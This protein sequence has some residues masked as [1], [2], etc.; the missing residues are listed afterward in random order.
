MERD[1]TEIRAGHRLI[2]KNHLAHTIS[3]YLAKNPLSIL[4]QAAPRAYS[5]NLSFPDELDELLLDDLY[6]L[7]HAFEEDA[8]KE[9]RDQRWWILKAALADRG[10]GIRLFSNREMLE[11]IFEEF[12]V[13]S[14][15]EE[16]EDDSE[17]ETEKGPSHG[18]GKE[19]AVNASQMREWTIQ[20]RR[21]L[22]YIYIYFLSLD[23]CWFIADILLQEYISK[24]LL[25]DPVLGST[26]GRK[27]HLR[28]ESRYSKSAVP[29]LT[30]IESNVH[31]VYVVAVSALSVYVHH[32]YLALFAPTPYDFPPTRGDDGTVDLSSHLTNTCIQ[33]VDDEQPPALV[34]STW[35]SLAEHVILGEGA[36]AGEKLG[37]ERI[38]K[39]ENDVGE[40]VSETFRAGISSGSG[41]Q[42]GSCHCL[43]CYKVDANQRPQPTRSFRIR[44]KSLDAI[45]LSMKLCKFLFSRLMR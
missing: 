14:S 36:Y 24:P 2:R 5:F 7:N 26:V 37:E 29:L 42:V 23:R 39:V 28:G 20:V 44:S 43:D 13:E 9:P 3:L 31:A 6:E 4:R 34:V 16:D 35:Q 33:S 1:L 18:Q 38:R 10:N 25:L 21:T 19:T 45:F 30:H 41:F 22:Y 17:G 15:D 32:P 8:D 11:E 40:I 27:F 12:Q